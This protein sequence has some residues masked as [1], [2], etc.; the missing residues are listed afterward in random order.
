MNDRNPVQRPRTLRDAAARDAWRTRQVTRTVAATTAAFALVSP[1]PGWAQESAPIKLD[2]LSIE[3]RLIETNPYAEPGAPYKARVSADERH[4]RPLAE[5]PATVSVL[6]KTQIEDSGYTDLRTILDAQ[7][8]ITLGTGENGNAFGDRYVIRGQEARSDVFVDGLRDPGM[9]IRESFATEQVEISKGPN[10]SFAGRGTSG[11]AINAV[12]KQAST[13]YDFTKV[14]TGFGT[15]RHT[16]LTL[17]TNQVLD[18]TAALRAN[19]LYGYEEVP[20]RGPTD[21]SRKGL[22]LSFLKDLS[23]STQWVLDYYG[24]RAK[25]NPDLGTFNVGISGATRVPFAN[26]PVYAQQPDFLSSDV[27]ALTSRLRFTLSPTARVVNLTRLGQS[28]NAYVATGARRSDTVYPT[29]AD[30]TAQTQAFPAI[31]LSTHQGWQD[32]DYIA[33]QT[34]L[35][36]QLE[37][38]GL[39]H[40][41]NVGL[42]LTDH[43]VRNGVYSITNPGV[44]CYTRSS[45]GAVNDAYCATDASGAAVN[46]VNTLMNRQITKGTWDSDWSIRTVALSAM[47]TVDLNARW[48]AFGGLRLDHFDYRLA[49]QNTGTGALADYDYK[50]TIV[51]GHLGLTFKLRADAIVYGSYSS[52]SDINGGE[53]DVGTSSGYGGAVVVD[54]AMAGAKPEKTQNFELGTKWNLHEGKLLASAAVFHIRKS[55]IME[56]NGYATTGTFNSA[57]SEVSGIEFGLSGN[58]TPRLSAQAGLAL[59]KSKVTRSATAANV[60]ARLANFADLSSSATLRY[61]FTPKLAVGASAKHE[62]ERCAG[63]PDT[64]APDDASGTCSQPVPAYTVVDA[65]AQYEI[66]KRSAVRVNVGNVFDR[67]YHLAAYRS[68]SFMYLGDARNVRVTLQH[69]F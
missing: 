61:Q 14:S 10:S 51:N 17:D 33:N 24:L 9:T 2:A 22:A 36:T 62:S 48:T 42:E 12:T 6:T 1:A 56:G 18:D 27:D 8:G 16:R 15:G 60:G 47:D 59:M 31:T 21:R 35:F 44:N 69:D 29:R 57:A 50:G 5:T 23:A 68:G 58:V 26:P 53:S 34:T 49:T 63:Q 4:Q 67:V 64:G 13:E 32:V 19:V 28:F 66:D 43:Q 3:G 40:E 20:G 11:G 55:D 54:G 45:S 65:F 39:K 30:A 46:G 37:W 38:A 7:P 52:A 25:D 41:V